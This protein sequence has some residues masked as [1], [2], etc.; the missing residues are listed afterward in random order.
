MQLVGGILACCFLLPQVAVA[1]TI[2]DA[3]IA[4]RDGVYHVSIDARIKAPLHVVVRSIT[5]YDNLA[6]INPSIEESQVLQALGPDKYR[7]RSVIKVCI[8]IYCKWVQHVQDLE[9]Q[10][11][12]TI[13]GITVPAGSDLRSGKAHWRFADSGKYT[14]MY[15]TQRFEPDFWVPPVIGLWMIKRTLVSE[16][17]LTAKNIEKMARENR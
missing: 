10:D 4:K 13:V 6:S 17:R 1:G 14:E 11:E 16:V 5:D 8:L 2:M 9:Q 15:F 3:S 12:K 7:V